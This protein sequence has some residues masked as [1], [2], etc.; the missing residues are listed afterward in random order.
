MNTHKRTVAAFVAGLVGIVAGPGRRV[1]R[2]P[3]GP[4]GS[5]TLD[6][7]IW[8]ANRGAAHDPRLRRRH[9]RPT[10]STV[11]MA[12]SSQPGDL[13]FAKGKLY[14]AE[15]FAAPPVDRAR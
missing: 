8:V 14:V 1:R 7:T 11:P 4:T 9:G 2:R 15:E 3:G 6:G 5:R 13:A 10:S 12:P